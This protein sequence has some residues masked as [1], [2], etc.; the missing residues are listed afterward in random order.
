MAIHRTAGPI[1]IPGSPRAPAFVRPGG[2]GH[3]HTQ[4]INFYTF[5]YGC[6]YTL[7]TCRM[8]CPATCDQTPAGC[9]PVGATEEVTCLDATCYWVADGVP[10]Y[11]GQC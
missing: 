3:N 1:R 5:Y 9:A 4:Q 6:A 8:S 10:A 7:Y 2:V 11:E